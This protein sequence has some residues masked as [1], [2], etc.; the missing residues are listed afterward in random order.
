LSH[1]FSGKPL[2]GALSAATGKR[3]FSVN[4]LPTSLEIGERLAKTLEVEVDEELIK[5]YYGKHCLSF[6]VSELS[7]EHGK[8]TMILGS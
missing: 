3:K 1:F 8:S 7:A 4:C 5:S 6:E 2:Q